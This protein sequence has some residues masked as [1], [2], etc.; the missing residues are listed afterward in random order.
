MSDIKHPNEIDVLYNSGKITLLESNVLRETWNDLKS[1]EKYEY[2]KYM[3]IED[4]TKIINDMTDLQLLRS[5]AQ[6]MRTSKNLQRSI[7]GWV[8]FFGI[9]YILTIV[10]F[11]FIN[12]TS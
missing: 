9:M 10:G 4:D 1:E 3:R 12:I 6:N 11:I 2:K 7:K 5:I 8:T